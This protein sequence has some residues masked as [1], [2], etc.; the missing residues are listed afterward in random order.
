MCGKDSDKEMVGQKLILPLLGM[1]WVVI[2]VSPSPTISCS[3]AIPNLHH[4][5]RLKGEIRSGFLVPVASVSSK[6]GFA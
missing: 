1:G 4:H 6:N 3:G 2:T 5:F